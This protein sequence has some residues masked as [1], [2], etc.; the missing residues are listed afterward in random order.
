MHMR[1]QSNFRYFN[2]LT[3]DSSKNASLHCLLRHAMDY[4]EPRHRYR[5]GWSLFRDATL[6]PW[7][8]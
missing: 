8:F 7:N 4:S 2:M 5:P 6:E 3:R 1:S